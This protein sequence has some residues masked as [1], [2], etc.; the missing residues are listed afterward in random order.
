[1]W[2]TNVSI[3]LPDRVIEDAALQIHSGRIVGFGPMTVLPVMRNGSDPIDGRGLMLVPGMI[4]MHGDML[5]REL[6]PRPNARLP[7]EM[8]LIELDKRL[9]AS[10][11]TLAYAAISF[12]EISIRNND[13]RKEQVADEVVDAIHMARHSLKV[14]MR[15][16]AR[17]EVTNQNAPP[18]LQK[19]IAHN[20]VQLISLN[21]HTPGQGQ[22]R[23]IE[24]YVDQM[25][26]WTSISDEY[27]G[28]ATRERIAQ[29]QARPVAW[30][31]IEA[32]C[33]DARAHGIAIASHDDDT[34]DKVR[35]MHS[36]G[37]RLC[38][39][40]VTL[41]AACE[42][43]R[44]GMRVVMGA[45]NALRGAS[46]TG[47]LSA[48]DAVRQ[49]QVDLL[50]SDYHPGCMLQAAF[51]M[52]RDGLVSLPQAIAMVT[53]NVASALGLADVGRI[54]RGARA[55]LVLVEP[56][57]CPRVRATWRAGHIIYSDGTIL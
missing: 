47:N 32:L 12:S 27:A 2:I 46:T 19:L 39:F 8:A 15:I 28:A 36:L 14:D 42:A 9:A 20:K 52:A 17:F 3:V 53:T 24:K 26:R 48:R 56:G 44:F 41:Q 30:D 13:L 11:V 31:I 33:H 54:S 7:Y 50:A 55:D 35:F 18:M 40:P 29:A 45:P 51:A 10:G 6:E 43:R 25:K 1:M 21:D 37:A 49:G 57:P 16:H 22:Y 38:E 23:D 4:D 5:E 34:P